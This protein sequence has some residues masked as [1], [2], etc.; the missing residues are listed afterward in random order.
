[1]VALLA[2]SGVRAADLSKVPQIHE[3]RE[4]RDERMQWFRDAKFGALISFNPSSITGGE[5][6]WSRGGPRP[7]DVNGHP[8]RAV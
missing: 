4:Q 5:I 7:L 6:G 8:A 3:S 1:M 2:T